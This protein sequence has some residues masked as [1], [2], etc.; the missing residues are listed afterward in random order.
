MNQ[1]KVFSFF[2]IVMAA[3]MIVLFFTVIAALPSSAIQ[4]TKHQSKTI[5]MIYP[6]S[7]GFFS[8]DPREDSLNIY[9]L[10]PGEK[11]R[12]PNNSLKNVIGLNRYGRTQGIE[13]G[14]MLEKLP[15]KE[16][17]KDY[18]AGQDI[19]NT[20]FLKVKNESPSPTLK[21]KMIIT[22]ERITPWAWSKHTKTKRTIKKFIGV[23]VN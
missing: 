16:K 20:T 9:P 21:G 7:W 3:W 5:S 22:Y 17:W 15:P 6:Q 19:K 12:W 8:K 23:D 18:T 1:N 11:L 13:L 10:T 14:L 2:F 4:L